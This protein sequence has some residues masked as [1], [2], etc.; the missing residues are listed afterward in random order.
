MEVGVSM[1]IFISVLYASP[2]RTY[3][4]PFIAAVVLL[5][6]VAILLFIIARKCCKKTAL[7]KKMAEEHE[8]K[9]RAE[10]ATIDTIVDTLSDVLF[11]KGL[12]LKYTR[13]NKSFKDLFGLDCDDIIG[14]SDQEM[15]I[16][17]DV[18][19]G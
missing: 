18:V 8:E 19:E 13:A 2:D 15:G 10:T 9:L 7:L 17:P 5:V 4:S 6:A 11:C 3:L 16:R 1:E 14:K 12:N